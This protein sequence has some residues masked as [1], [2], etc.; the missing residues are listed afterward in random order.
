MALDMITTISLEAKSVQ[1][2]TLT[3]V[4]TIHGPLKVAS[5][6]ATKPLN[7]INYIPASL[8]LAD[9]ALFHLLA[10]QAC[11]LKQVSIMKWL[12]ITM[13]VEFLAVMSRFFIMT[14]K[15]KSSTKTT[16][17]TVRRLPVTLLVL[18]LGRAGQN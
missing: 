17:Q 3:Q 5:V 13:A 7:Q 11:N 4:P 16:Y 6:P 12:L 10:P 9:K 14:L 1:G 8:V 2:F 15:T 18:T